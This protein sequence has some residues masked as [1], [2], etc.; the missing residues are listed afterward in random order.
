MLGDGIW[1]ASGKD[2][3]IIKDINAFLR[4]TGAK[5]VSQQLTSCYNERVKE[6]RTTVS[7]VYKKESK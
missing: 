3:E 4:E 5:I 7:I 1:V 2:S 6:T